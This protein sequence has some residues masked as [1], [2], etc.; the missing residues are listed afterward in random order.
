MS[1]NSARHHI[2]CLRISYEHENQSCRSSAT[3]GLPFEHGLTKEDTSCVKGE[4]AMCSR[5]SSRCRNSLNRV[6]GSY[7]FAI[8]WID[9]PQDRRHTEGLKEI[10]KL[11]PRVVMQC[12]LKCLGFTN[13]NIYLMFACKEYGNLTY[14]II[15]RVLSNGCYLIGTRIDEWSKERNGVK[16]DGDA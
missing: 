16:V 8:G 10:G 5:P 13:G 11:C 1:Q 4:W 12:V 3:Q 2:S 14:V 9:M 15:Q 6:L 7:L